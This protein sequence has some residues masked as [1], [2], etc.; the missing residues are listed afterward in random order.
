[1]RNPDPAA[2]RPAGRAPRHRVRVLLAESDVI[3]RDSLAVLLE[4][5][6][7]AVQTAANADEALAAA[8]QAGWDCLVTDLHLPGM[9]GVELYARLL[10]QGRPRFPAV[11]LSP[12]PPLTLELGLRGAPWVRLLRKP[13][14]FPSLLVAL[15]SCLRAPRGM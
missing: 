12:R 3:V 14:T 5:A 13:C 8:A 2:V 10:F 15:E 1:V 7:Y 6:G 4:R 9:G 11:F